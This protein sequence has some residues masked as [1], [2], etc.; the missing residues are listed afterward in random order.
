MPSADNTCFPSHSLQLIQTFVSYDFPL[1]VSNEAVGVRPS[2]SPRNV[3]TPQDSPYPNPHTHTCP[4][5]AFVCCPSLLLLPA[6]MFV[7]KFRVLLTLPRKDEVERKKVAAYR[8][9]PPIT[10]QTPPSLG[11]SWVAR[12]H[13]LFRHPPTPLGR[14]ERR[15]GW[16]RDPAK[17]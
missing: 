17:K 1:S 6:S 3:T 9:F 13:G 5:P 15:G 14:A 4:C 8:E 12:S 2:R 16:V 11:E 7:S 10:H